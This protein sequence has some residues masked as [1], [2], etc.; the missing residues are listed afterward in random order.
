MAKEPVN[1]TARWIEGLDT[2]KLQELRITQPKNPI[3]PQLWNLTLSGEFT[4]LHI[5]LKVMLG[6]KLWINDYM[7]CQNPFR[8]SLRASAICDDEHGFMSPI[9]LEVA[10]LDPFDWKHDANWEDAMGSHISLSVDYGQKSSV[11]NQVRE[12][13]VSQIGNVRIRLADQTVWDPL[14][15]AAQILQTVVR[16]N[17]GSKC[18]RMGANGT[19]TP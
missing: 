16:Q 15:V 6:G 9:K 10:Q 19:W 2:V 14:V 7:C 4:G 12:V 11:Q 13:F 17:S 3:G 18:P 5:W 8:F 1:V